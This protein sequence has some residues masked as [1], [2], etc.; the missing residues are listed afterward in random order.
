M[1]GIYG[2]NTF[3]SLAKRDTLNEKLPKCP[4]KQHKSEDPAEFTPGPGCSKAG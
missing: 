2:S 4:A 1:K 3:Y